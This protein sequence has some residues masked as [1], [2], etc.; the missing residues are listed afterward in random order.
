MTCFA[1]YIL[2][3]AT[4]NV[5]YATSFAEWGFTTSTSIIA[6][7]EI[8]STNKFRTVTAS[9]PIVAQ[10]Y[11]VSRLALPDFMAVMSLCREQ[12]GSKS[13]S[14]SANMN[15][16]IR[17]LQHF[18]PKFVFPDVMQHKMIGLRSKKGEIVAFADVSLQP[19][20]GTID[21]LATRSY[22]NRL[23]KYGSKELDPYVCN[24][25]VAPEVRRQGLGK[26][27]LKECEKAALSF[28][29]DEL[30]LHVEKRGLPALRLYKGSGYEVLPTK[31]RSPGME[32]VHMRKVLRTE[33]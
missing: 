17:I 19:S 32:V 9:P 8:S 10:E 24:F 2:I 4:L 25:L 28:K 22:N 7:P 14:P 6:K 21:A 33:P 26:K 15:L 1:I 11:H 18:L 23:K 31:V 13:L 16:L 3:L 20:S 30:Y 12:F 5:R 27:L 29:K